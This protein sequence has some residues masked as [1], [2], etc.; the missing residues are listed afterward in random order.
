VNTRHEPIAATAAAP[1]S[2]SAARAVGA[3]ASD[4][5]REAADAFDP[6]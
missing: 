2:H 1:A 3:A 4:G 6:R 5:G